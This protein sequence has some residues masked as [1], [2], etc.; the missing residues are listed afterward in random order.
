MSTQLKIC[1][2]PFEPNI[3]IVDDLVISVS[4]PYTENNV[5]VTINPNVTEYVEGKTEGDV[6]IAQ[7]ME[8]RASDE[9]ITTKLDVQ[10]NP[11]QVFV[12]SNSW[13]LQRSYARARNFCHSSF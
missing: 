12:V 6:Q 1:L 8:H 10:N 7:L 2:C 4:P 5:T 11:K 9:T 13:G 3:G